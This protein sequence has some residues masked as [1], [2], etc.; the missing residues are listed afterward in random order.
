MNNSPNMIEKT[1]A[2][3]KKVLTNAESGH[4]WWHTY[5][6]WKMARH[7]ASH[8]PESDLLVIEL[9]SVLHDVADEKFD[10]F[11]EKKILLENYIHS[12]EI[13]T[14]QK[15]HILQIIGNLSFRKSYNAHTEQTVELQI[16]QD[17]DRLDAIGAIGIARAFSYGGYKQREMYNPEIKPK[18]FNASKE[19]Q[20]SK[21]PTI[22]HFYEKLLLL[23][24]KM[25]TREGKHIAV[26]RHEFMIK[27]IEKFY[28][29]W[30]GKK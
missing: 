27:Y 10:T 9:A 26:E 5:R 25:N 22:N 1:I 21:S 16:V 11:K 14:T 7:L 20:K 17:A 15:E 3:A 28:A 6:V 4:D 8:Y 19:Y 29:E 2:F 23:K 24:D 18:K 12:L 30:E 13:T